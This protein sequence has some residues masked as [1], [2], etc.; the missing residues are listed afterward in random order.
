MASQAPTGWFLDPHGTCD[1]VLLLL[2][3][4]VRCQTAADELTCRYWRWLRLKLACGAGSRLSPWDLEDAQ[5][6][7]YFWIQEAVQAYDPAQ[8]SLPEGSSFR[9]FTYRVFRLRLLDWRRSL[10]RHKRRQRALGEPD[11]LLE[12]RPAPGD[13]SLDRKR[14]LEDAL[15]G[16]DAPTRALWTQLCQGKRLCELPEVLA[17]SYRTLKRRWRKLREHIA[18]AGAMLPTRRRLTPRQRID[19]LKGN[20]G[21]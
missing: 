20:R 15:R 3:R 9:T 8:L 10:G 1:E 14:G 16:L 13:E 6:Q 12:N 5:Q 19:H 4:E 21:A 17:V 11:Q 7:A 18:W 2:A